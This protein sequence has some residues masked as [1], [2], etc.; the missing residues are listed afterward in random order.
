MNKVLSLKTVRTKST[1]VGNN[2]LGPGK[3]RPNNQC[4]QI[5]T[6][7]CCFYSIIF[8][9]TRVRVRVCVRVIH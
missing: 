8:W 9:K 1:A 6:K 7:L 3:L 2:K 5:Q 4:Q